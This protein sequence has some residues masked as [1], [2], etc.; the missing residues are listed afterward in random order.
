MAIWGISLLK[1]WSWTFDDKIWPF[2]GLTICIPR[3]EERAIYACHVHLYND[4]IIRTTV[5]IYN[6]IFKGLPR[7]LEV[8]LDLFIW[9]PVLR[10]TLLWRSDFEER[11]SVLRKMEQSFPWHV[12]GEQTSLSSVTVGNSQ[13]STAKAPLETSQNNHETRSQKLAA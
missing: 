13:N 12:L 6:N 5:Y 4:P 3:Q 1:R 11:A 9:D 10:V 2:L 8:A 7:N